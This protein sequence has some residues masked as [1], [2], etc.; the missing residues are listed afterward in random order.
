MRNPQKQNCAIIFIINLTIIKALKKNPYCFVIKENNS[1]VSVAQSSRENDTHIAINHV[2]TMPGYRKRG[3]ASAIVAYLSR[4]IQQ[5]GKIPT[6]FTDLSNPA[7]NKAY[8][9]VGFVEKS[10]VDEI[11]LNWN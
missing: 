9:N 6:L 10:P 5:K 3:C 8:K 7:A 1:V 2:Y 11:F 4:L